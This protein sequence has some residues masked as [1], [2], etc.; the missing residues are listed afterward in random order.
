MTIREE[1]GEASKKAKEKKNLTHRYVGSG[2]VI[3]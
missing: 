2:D 3:N 1:R